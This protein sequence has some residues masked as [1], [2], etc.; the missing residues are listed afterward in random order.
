MNVFASDGLQSVDR[1]M[2]LGRTDYSAG[3]VLLRL[4]STARR[5]RPHRVEIRVCPAV[6][7]ACRYLARRVVSVRMAQRTGREW[8]T[9]YHSIPSSTRVRGEHVTM[10]PI[11]PV[12]ELLDVQHGVHRRALRPSCLAESK[13]RGGTFATAARKHGA[14]WERAPHI[15]ITF[16]STVDRVASVPPA[17]PAGQM[18]E[19]AARP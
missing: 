8:R 4:V 12:Y 15:A 11:P 9:S 5:P 1:R 10:S 6:Q 19:P 7:S 13:V 2:T 3:P 14:Y 18:L 17:V 16:G